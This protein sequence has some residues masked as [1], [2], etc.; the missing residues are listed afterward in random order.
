MPVAYSFTFPGSVDGKITGLLGT[1][2]SAVGIYQ[3]WPWF[4]HICLFY[5]IFYI[6]YITY[7][8]YHNFSLRFL[9]QIN[10]INLKYKKT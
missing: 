3:M 4:N 9:N 7:K 5:F 6:P 8:K 2:T 10:K 1:F